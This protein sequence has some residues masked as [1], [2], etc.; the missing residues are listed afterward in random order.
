MAAVSAQPEVETKVGTFRITVKVDD[1]EKGDD[2][3]EGARLNGDGVAVWYENAKE[4]FSYPVVPSLVSALRLFGASV[5]EDQEQFLEESLKGD[6]TGPAVKRIVEIIN[7]DLRDSAK[8]SAYAKLV[9]EHTP[10]TEENLSNAHASAIRNILKS[11]PAL[12][13]ETV[14]D[15]LKAFGSLPADYTVEQFRANKGKR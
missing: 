9:N 3:P 15:G 2:L 7:S 11:N 10:L 13:V 12:S 6:S 8:A 5:S 14:I 4:E 1:W